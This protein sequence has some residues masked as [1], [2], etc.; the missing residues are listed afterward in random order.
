MNSKITSAI[1]QSHIWVNS[2]DL[3][4]YKVSG[5]SVCKLPKQ[6]FLVFGGIDEKGKHKN[7]YFIYHIGMYN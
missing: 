3:G 7:D 2:G 5:H 1:L 4:D 6:R